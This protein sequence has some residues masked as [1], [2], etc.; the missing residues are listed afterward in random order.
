MKKAGL[1]LAAV[2]VSLLCYGATSRDAG[3]KEKK[4]ALERKYQRCM[5]YSR[6]KEN[7][8]KYQDIKNSIKQ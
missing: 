2:T 7:C 1:I 8:Q 5:K 4:D 3:I 6:Y